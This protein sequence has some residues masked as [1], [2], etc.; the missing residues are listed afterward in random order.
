MMKK[1][2][3]KII[4]FV[5]LGAILVVSFATIVYLIQSKASFELPPKKHILVI[6]DSSTECAIND[7]IYSS[8]INVSQSASAYL[9][10]YSKLKKFLS[11]NNHVDTVLISFHY[12]ALMASHIDNRWIFGSEFMDNKIPYY[13]ALLDKEV[14]SVFANDKVAFIKAIVLHPPYRIIFKFIT[15][16]GSISY[17]DLNIGAYKKLDRDKLQE[18]IAI[19]ANNKQIENKE[20]NIS[21]YQKEYLLKIIDLCKSRNVKL[22][23]ITT[24]TYKPEM[25]G[26]IDKL[27]DY[28]N[29]YLSG[30]KHVD[31]SDFLLPDSC[32]GDISHLNY[33]GAEIFS[34]YLQENFSTTVKLK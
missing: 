17:E 4:L 12:D 27:N 20:M 16:K 2:I 8:A 22:I 29:T 28:Y 26:T 32:Y 21:L 11:E 5:F 7:D 10:S 31:C 18:N 3:N 23:L 13:F 25:Y 6:G 34:K 24:P 33:K 19:N 14:I 15:K 30:I 9:Y 1:F